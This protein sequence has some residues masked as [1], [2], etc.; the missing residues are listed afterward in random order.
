MAEPAVIMIWVKRLFLYSLEPTL[1]IT[2]PNPQK[3]RMPKPKGTPL[4]ISF[5]SPP[6]SPTPLPNFLPPYNA[7]QI[8]AISIISGFALQISMQ[9]NAV[10]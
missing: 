10:D 6:V 7:K 8:T 3:D 1:P 2:K 9:H 5:N 4:A